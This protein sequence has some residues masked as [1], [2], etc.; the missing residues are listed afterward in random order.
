MFDH[1]ATY[2]Y[3]YVVQAFR[4][5]HDAKANGTAGRSRDIKAA[6]AAASALF[7]LREHLPS[8][9]GLTRSAAEK[10]CSDYGLLGDIANASKHND[11]GGK[12]PHGE[13]LVKSAKNLR[14]EIVSTEYRDEFGTYRHVEKAVTAT[15]TDGTTR[16]VLE[17]LTNVMNFWQS[18]FRDCHL[19]TEAVT[20][21]IDAGNEPISRT[22]A[23]HGRIDLELSGGLPATLRARIRRYNYDTGEIELVDLTDS[24]ATFTVRKPA[25]Y[26]LDIALTHEATGKRLSM[27]IELTGQESLNYSMLPTESERQRYAAGLPSVQSGYRKLHAELESPSHDTDA[28]PLAPG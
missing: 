25:Q 3:E 24:Q 13:P 10:L 1:L 11:I 9:C 17:V 28:S 23:N 27:S 2:F 5:Y 12:T 7:H 18:Y 22:D 4:D 14:E 8:E 21:T 20:Y 6:L 16:D 15:L 26:T 19:I